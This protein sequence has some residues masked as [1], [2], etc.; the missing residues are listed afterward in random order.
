MKKNKPLWIIS[1]GGSLINPDGSPDV[2]FLKQFKS[3]IVEM[4]ESHSFLFI[5][6]GGK[7]TRIYQN[8]A[9]ELGV[10]D[11]TDLDWIGIKATHTNAELFRSLFQDFAPDR[12]YTDPTDHMDLLHPVTVFGGWKPGWSTDYDAVLAAE[13]FGATKIVNMSN[14]E[15][16]Y[17]DDPKT[18]PNAEKLETT[19]WDQLQKIIG[20]EWTPGMNAP[21]DPKAIDKARSLGL[22]V[23]FASGSNLDNL[24]SLL[25][26]ESFVGTT[27][28]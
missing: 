15:Y 16:V 2:E 17:T 23:Y 21:F 5:T 8:A 13:T 7:I 12:I 28:S 18:N 24:Q 22:T 3:K 19:T 20:T 10:T 9:R 26:G 4:I 1:L 6:G 11:S 14:I 25:R 27:I